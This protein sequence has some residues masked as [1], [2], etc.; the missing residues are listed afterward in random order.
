MADLSTKL[1]KAYEGKSLAELVNALVTALRGVSAATRTTPQGRVRHRHDR[2]VGHQPD[3][4]LGASNPN[5]AK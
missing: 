2:R 4:P 5:L 1:D 3:L